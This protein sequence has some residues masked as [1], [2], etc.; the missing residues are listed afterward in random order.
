MTDYPDTIWTQ[1]QRLDRLAHL[2]HL[3]QSNV[4]RHGMPFTQ[5]SQDY[6]LE[7]IQA[8]S[9][10]V[11]QASLAGKR[12]SFTEEVSTHHD[13]QD[14]TSLLDT[15]RQHAFTVR[16][17]TP[18]QEFL[19]FVTPHFNHVDGISSGQF[20]NGLPF[21]CPH[22]NDQAFFIGQDRIYFYRHLLRAY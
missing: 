15:M 20:A 13:E 18:S 16:A 9:D 22:A 4:F 17:I 14:I 5:R 21:N 7:L 2:A 8:V 10:L 19:T 12:I 6:W 1:L 11:R 3:L